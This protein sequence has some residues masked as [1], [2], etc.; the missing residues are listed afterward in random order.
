MHS[1]INCLSDN[2]RRIEKRAPSAEM[3]RAHSPVPHN[4]AKQTRRLRALAAFSS[5]ESLRAAARTMTALSS[6]GSLPAGST[7]RSSRVNIAERAASAWSTRAIGR[8]HRALAAI[9]ARSRRCSGVTLRSLRRLPHRP[10]PGA[11]ACAGDYVVPAGRDHPRCQ[12]ARRPQWRRPGTHG[13]PGRSRR[14]PWPRWRPRHREGRRS[15]G[16]HRCRARERSTAAL[17]PPR[18]PQAGWLTGNRLGQGL[19]SHRPCTL[20]P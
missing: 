12:M 19:R 13:V 9:L 15:P 17:C 3:L 4:Y 10:L 20:A 11:V 14:L 5:A 6:G 7:C 1:F 2:T 18:R 16:W 8:A